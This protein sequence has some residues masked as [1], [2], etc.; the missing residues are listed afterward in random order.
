MQGAEALWRT[1][2]AGG[3]ELVLANPGTTEMALVAALDHLPGMRPVLCLDEGVVTGAADGYARVA[4]RPAVSLLHHGPGLANGLANLHNARRARSAVVNV[5]GDNTRRH[6]RHDPLLNT[7]I[8]ALAASAS[9]W[10]RSVT[11][12]SLLAEDGAAALAAACE[13]PGGVSTLIVPADCAAASGVEPAA[14]APPRGS[15]AV[16]DRDVAVVARRLRAAARPA[17]LA[18]GA[19]LEAAGL[20][21]AARV[22]AC[23]GARLLCDTF[24]ARLEWGR[25]RHPVERL[26]YFPEPAL[27]QLAGTDLLVVVATR[28]PVA[29]FE[30]P[31]QPGLLTPP[32]CETVTLARPDQDAVAALEALADRLEAPPA[33]PVPEAAP[34]P[35][36]RGVLDA[37]A[38]AAAVGRHMPEGAVVSEEALT[39]ALPLLPMCRAAPPHLWLALT[40]GA[41]GQ[42]LPVATGAALAAPGRKVISLQADGSGMYTLQSLWTQAREGLDVTTVIYANRQYRILMA[43]LERGGGRPG[44]ALAGMVDIGR[45]ALDWVALAC[46]MGVEAVRAETAEDFD[47]AYARALA[48]PGPALVEAVLGE[49]SVPAAT[50][51]PGAPRSGP[52]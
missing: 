6:R 11:D 8:E 10:V 34:P 25:D 41:I 19:A 52:E 5:V 31:G 44:P 40:G 9:R 38:I 15:S 51:R 26:A 18:S 7:D 48:S 13:P 35:P 23:C 47:D 24:N 29:F 1:L 4:G 43:E 49:A 36:P 39:G 33:V 27:E 50:H 16:A 28:A 2:H 21:A 14:P 30:W 42:G 3:V 12:P 32:G 22:A 37:A 20:A 45:P 46:G 17:L